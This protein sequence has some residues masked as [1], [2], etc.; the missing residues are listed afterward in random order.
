[1]RA[2]TFLIGDLVT[3]WTGGWEARLRKQYENRAGIITNIRVE[4]KYNAPPRYFVNFGTGVVEVA[5]SRL[6]HLT[7]KK[8]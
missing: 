1:M 4:M 2:E 8:E 3:V 6:R 7:R 5:E